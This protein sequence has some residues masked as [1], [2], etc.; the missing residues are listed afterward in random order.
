MAL[1]AP[2]ATPTMTCKTLHPQLVT[3]LWALAAASAAAAG[4]ET[5][6]NLS[7]SDDGAF[8]I[9][10]RTRVAWA[11]CVEGMRGTGTT[12][13]GVADRLDHAGATARVAQRRRSDGLNWRLP[14]VRELQWLLK[15]DS[16]TKRIDTTR[17]PRASD[18]W[19]WSASVS[20]DSSTV[21]PYNYSNIRSGVTAENVNRIAYL[22]G[23]AVHLGSGE[24]NGAI[25]KR[26]RLPV[27]LVLPLE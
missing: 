7:A 17:F 5:A 26:T 18:G 13:S 9:D 23:W 14:R 19:H 25:N 8:V 11:R 27:R 21:N 3:V 24:A 20:I 1:S 15:S 4:D 2:A 12:C 22:H 16:P 6:D 10:A